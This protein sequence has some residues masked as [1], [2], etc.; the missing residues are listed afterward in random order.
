MSAQV[1]FTPEN[2]NRRGYAKQTLGANTRS[3]EGLFY[4]L[5]G[6]RKQ[7]RRHLRAQP[8]G[9]LR[10]MT[11]VFDNSLPGDTKKSYRRLAREDQLASW[12]RAA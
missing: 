5:V 11:F 8:L 7:R 1:G 6:E 3:R 4:R 9:A 12:F 10:L 2:G